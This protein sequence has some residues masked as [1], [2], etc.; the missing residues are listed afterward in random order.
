MQ[1]LWGSVRW[2]ISGPHYFVNAPA[3]AEPIT[4]Q[5]PLLQQ[6]LRQR[7]G[8]A[9]ALSILFRVEAE[10]FVITE[11]Q[12]IAVFTKYSVTAFGFK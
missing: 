11:F 4:A 7:A 10:D 12:P 1:N 5:M 8:T 9:A 3:R 6:I 2:V